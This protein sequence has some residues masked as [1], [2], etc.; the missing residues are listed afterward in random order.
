MFV[1]YKLSIF[2]HCFFLF[3]YLNVY[4]FIY[5]QVIKIKKEKTNMMYHTFGIKILDQCSIYM[6]SFLSIFICTF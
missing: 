1:L 2:I 6:Y 3:M 4:Y 5:H